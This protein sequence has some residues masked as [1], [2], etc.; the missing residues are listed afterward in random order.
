MIEGVEVTLLPLFF[1][2]THWYFRCDF[3]TRGRNL[4]LTKCLNFNVY[5]GGPK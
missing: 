3:L 5:T 2:D 1:F 4:I